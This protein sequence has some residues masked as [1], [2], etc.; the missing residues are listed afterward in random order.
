MTLAPNGSGPIHAFP[1]R[2]RALIDNAGNIDWRTSLDEKPV[3]FEHDG[4]IG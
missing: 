3:V 4:M 1:D 2:E